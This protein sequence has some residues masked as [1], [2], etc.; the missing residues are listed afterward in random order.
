MG[1][2]LQSEPKG[3]NHL[4]NLLVVQFSETS[5]AEDHKIQ[6][7]NVA[8]MVPERFPDQTLDAVAI[9][10]PLD[11]LFLPERIR[12]WPGPAHSVLPAAGDAASYH[13][14]PCYQKPV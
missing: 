6:C 12:F 5:P 10:S 3:V 8:L 14:A 9:H 4:T 11:L 7:I 13:A 1:W 2:T